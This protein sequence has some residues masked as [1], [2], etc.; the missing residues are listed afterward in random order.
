MYDVDIKAMATCICKH[1]NKTAGDNLYC[2]NCTSDCFPC[3]FSIGIAK[4]LIENRYVNINNVIDDVISAYSDF[5]NYVSCDDY[6]PQS[7][8]QE[9]TEEHRDSKYIF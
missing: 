6:A 5:K 8:V 3:G 1:L 2:R 7:K 9:T 4:N